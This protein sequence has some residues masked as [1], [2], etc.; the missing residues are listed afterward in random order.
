MTVAGRASGRAPPE[1]GEA[2]VRELQSIIVEFE[3]AEAAGAPLVLATVV[4]VEGST[5]RRPGARLLMSEDRWLA[6]GVS[7]GCLEGDVLKRA[8]WRTAEGSPVLVEYDSRQDA[9][10][11]WT[12]ALGC[13][14]LVEVLLERIAPDAPVHPIRPVG[15]WQR[16]DRGWSGSSWAG[17]PSRR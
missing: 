2:A 12:H 6:G 14:G 5:Y 10:S 15:R 8:F 9:D 13:N 3:R 11:A 16:G 7:G 17:E 1:P 4:H